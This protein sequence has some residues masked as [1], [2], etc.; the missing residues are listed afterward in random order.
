MVNFSL[1]L[2]HAIHVIGFAVLEG[3]LCLPNIYL[4]LHEQALIEDTDCNK[5]QFKQDPE[6]SRTFPY[7]FYALRCFK[8]CTIDILIN[9]HKARHIRL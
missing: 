5:P 3:F 8:N 6:F 2:N 4:F 9:D 7:I 1:K